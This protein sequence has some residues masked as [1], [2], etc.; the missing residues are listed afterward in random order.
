MH[1]A[2]AA[3]VQ[4]RASLG[5]SFL[6]F[7]FLVDSLRSSGI[8]ADVVSAFLTGGLALVGRASLKTDITKLLPFVSDGLVDLG[9]VLVDEANVH[10]PRPVFNDVAGGVPA[11]SDELSFLLIVLTPVEEV[12]VALEDV[13]ALERVV[14]VVER[15]FPLGIVVAEVLGEVSG[16]LFLVLPRYLDLE[17]ATE[18]GQLL[19]LLL[20]LLLRLLLLRQSLLV[21]LHILPPLLV[22]LAEP[23]LLD[24]L[25]GVVLFFLQMVVP[26]LH[27]LAVNGGGIGPG[28]EAPLLPLLADC[29][30][31]LLPV[32]APVEVGVELGTAKASERVLR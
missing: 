31:G 11:A 18:P 15:L 19:Q 29:I 32:L 21:E 20:G 27:L 4:L 16:V 10:L 13:V 9:V 14:A 12:V 22:L 30:G 7:V 5:R 26:P 23:P 17:T 8:F 6:H 28:G 3:L 25:G 2:E 24:L 1:G